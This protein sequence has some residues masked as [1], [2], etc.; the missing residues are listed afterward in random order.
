MADNKLNRAY[1]S[2]ATKFLQDFDQKSEAWS[3]A[4]EAEVKKYDRINDLRDKVQPE[5]P[6]SKIWSGF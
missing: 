3:P 2:E 4:R 6:A 5:K 1:V